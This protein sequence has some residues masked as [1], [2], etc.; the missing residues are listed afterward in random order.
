MGSYN[1]ALQVGVLVGLLAGMVQMA[2]AL[3][4]EL[5][6]GQPRLA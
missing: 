5:P 4:S 1:R 6:P 3:R 2:F